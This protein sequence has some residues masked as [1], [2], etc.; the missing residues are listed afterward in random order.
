MIMTMIKSPTVVQLFHPTIGYPS[1]NGTIGEAA[2]KE[3]RKSIN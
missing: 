2:G 1:A 3:D